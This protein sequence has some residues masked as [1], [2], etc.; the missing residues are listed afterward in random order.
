M[1][2]FT[3]MQNRKIRYKQN[4]GECIFIVDHEVDFI[5]T[6]KYAVAMSL[7]IAEYKNEIIIENLFSSG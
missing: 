2:T 7:Y 1:V 5:F 6:R 3:N 4:V